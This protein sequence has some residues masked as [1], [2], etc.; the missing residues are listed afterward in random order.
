MS[1]KIA[2]IQG[3][4]HANHGHYGDALAKAYEEGAA[5]GGHEVR[6]LTVAQMNFPLLQ[7]MEEWQKA[8]PNEDI[9]AAQ[10]TVKWA[11]HLV[12]LYP[13]WLGSMPAMLKGFLEQLLR[14]GF[15][16]DMPEGTHTWQRLLK[17][18]SARVVVTMGM[19]AF[20]YRWYFRAHSLKNLERNILKLCGIDPVRATLIGMVEGSD[21]HRKKAL[22]KLRRLGERGE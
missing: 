8:K 18:K 22:A 14:P 9:Q 1:K 4:P 20:A 19:P 2:I 12:I 15:S 7:S 11:E 21:R 5:A 10:E 16:I 6:W 17:G 13:L 3:H